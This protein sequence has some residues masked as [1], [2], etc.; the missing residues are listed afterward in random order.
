MKMKNSHI[1][2]LEY[3]EGLSDNSTS[4]N[5][6]VSHLSWIGLARNRGSIKNSGNK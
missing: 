4:W 3:T 2:F 1:Q 5:D 6:N